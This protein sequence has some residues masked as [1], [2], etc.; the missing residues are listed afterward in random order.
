MRTNGKDASWTVNGRKRDGQGFQ[1]NPSQRCSVCLFRVQASSLLSSTKYLVIHKQRAHL[2]DREGPIDRCLEAELPNGVW[3]CSNVCE[4]A[5]AQQNRVDSRG[6]PKIVE[7]D[8][9]GA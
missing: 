2:L 7:K 1:R 9:E 6:P 3:K 4:A 8:G 5:V